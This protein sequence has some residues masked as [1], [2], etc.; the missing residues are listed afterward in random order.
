M[1]VGWRW[2]LMA[3]GGWLLIDRGW[4]LVDVGWLAMV[5]LLLVVGRRSSLRFVGCLWLV[6]T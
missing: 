5:G 1:L 4:L 3:A 2:R 6:V